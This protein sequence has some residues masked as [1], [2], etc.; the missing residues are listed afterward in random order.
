[1]KKLIPILVV[2]ALGLTVQ[3]SFAA[4]PP[5]PAPDTGSTALLLAAA[6]GGLSWV[7]KRVRR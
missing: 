6:M 2:I 7:A 1:M 5:P 3:S 4:S